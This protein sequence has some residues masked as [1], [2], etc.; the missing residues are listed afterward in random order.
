[1]KVAFVLGRH[2]NHAPGI[3]VFENAVGARQCGEDPKKLTAL[4]GVL[5]KLPPELAMPD[6]ATYKQWEDEYDSEHG[7]AA[8]KAAAL[9]AIETQNREAELA[10]AVSDKDAPQAV[11]DYAA[12][13]EKVK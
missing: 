2:F 10:F 12:E 4:G 1:M 8:K 13:L 9:K 5:V 6:S 3:R 11:K 7:L